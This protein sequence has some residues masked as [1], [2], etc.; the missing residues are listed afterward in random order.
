MKRKFDLGWR[1]RLT[2]E[3]VEEI[4]KLILQLLSGKSFILVSSCG[5]SAPDIT[6]NVI[7]D[8]GRFE[9]KEAVS[10][11]RREDEGSAGIDVVT[12]EEIGHFITNLR[13]GVFDR[14]RQGPFVTFE[15]D[16]VSITFRSGASI[17]C[18]WQAVVMEEDDLPK[19]DMKM[20]KKEMTLNEFLAEIREADIKPF[21]AEKIRKDFKEG[22]EEIQCTE[23]P[24]GIRLQVGGGRAKSFLASG[25]EKKKELSHLWGVVITDLVESN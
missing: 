23:Y 4:A 10:W 12:S 24:N 22:R 9:L 17:F 20:E 21:R 19:C 7:I 15:G 18:H 5:D 16:R 13:E 2:I 6:K 11:W 3:N 8:N 25:Y 1:G 14:S